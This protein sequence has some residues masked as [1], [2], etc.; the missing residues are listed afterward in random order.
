L[1]NYKKIKTSDGS[2][3]YYSALFDENCHSTSGAKNE[4]YTHYVLGC[5][6]D[7]KVVQKKPI[8]ILEVGFG[9]G[10]GFITTLEYLGKYPFNFLSVEIDEKMIQIAQKEFSQLLKLEKICAYIYKAKIQNASLTILLG[11]ATKTLNKYFKE[12]KYKPNTIYQDAFSPKRNPYLWTTSWFKLLKENATD[13][14]IMSTYS[15]S[16]SIRK[17]MLAAGW[18]LQEGIKFGSK[19]SSTRSDLCLA[20]EDTILEKLK[21]SGAPELTIKIAK[22]Y[23]L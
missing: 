10:L 5:K 15:S 2:Y 8:N 1:E 21:R 11:D 14:C 13:D 6:L 17:S 23:K 3:T 18:T 20:T 19:R 22:D 7:R 9:T 4:T 16:S 12:N